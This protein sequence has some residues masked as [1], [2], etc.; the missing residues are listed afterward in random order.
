M[1]LER[2]IAEFKKFVPFKQ[3][4]FDL[5]AK[6]LTVV[7]LK[8]NEIWEDIFKVS[9]NMGFV[10]SGILRQYYIKEGVEYTDN[11]YLESAFIGNYISYL[12]KT[13]STTITV[14]LEPCELLIV[15]FRE[16]E[17]LYKIMPVSEQFSKAIGEQKLFK[18]NSR[19]ASL[20]MDS[21]E[22]RYSK[23]LQEK[24]ALINR[25][26]QY[27]IAQYLGIRPESLSRIRKKRIS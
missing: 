21:P 15:P 24:P 2:I 16:L 9:Q 5:F 19:N 7:N 13:P 27:L 4:E 22:E 26:P 18:L 6:R 3:E 17:K 14:A 11:F 25:V 10:N 23:L 20:L 8:K 12:S 1:E